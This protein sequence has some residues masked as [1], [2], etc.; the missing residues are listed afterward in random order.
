MVYVYTEYQEEPAITLGLHRKQ[1]VLDSDPKLTA[2]LNRAD[3]QLKP[4][5]AEDLPREL[6]R[7][8]EVANRLDREAGVSGED[9]YESSFHRYIADQIQEAMNNGTKE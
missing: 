5:S 4:Y 8:N 3:R 7:H 6:M 1:I 9:G 2:T